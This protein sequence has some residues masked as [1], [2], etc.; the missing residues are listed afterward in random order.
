MENKKTNKNLQTS[1][2]FGEERGK[3]KQTNNGSAFQN[4][5]Q[6]AQ[7][8]VQ[9]LYRSYGDEEHVIDFLEVCTSTGNNEPLKEAYRFLLLQQNNQAAQSLAETTGKYLL[10]KTSSQ[11]T[12]IHQD[13]TGA[14]KNKRPQSHQRKSEDGI[15]KNNRSGVRIPKGMNKTVTPNIKKDNGKI[16]ARMNRVP[17]SDNDGFQTV[18]VNLYQTYMQRAQD[19]LQGL[20]ASNKI[21]EFKLD[22]F[23]RQIT[24]IIKLGF[25]PINIFNELNLETR[26]LNLTQD[27]AQYL[28]NQL[29]NPF[30]SGQPIKYYQQEENGYKKIQTE[31]QKLENSKN[32]TAA[33]KKRNDSLSDFVNFFQAKF[34]L[35]THKRISSGANDLGDSTFED[36]G[37]NSSSGANTDKSI[38]ALLDTPEELSPGMRKDAVKELLKDPLGENN[39]GPLLKH[40]VAGKMCTGW[41]RD[42]GKEGDQY[43]KDTSEILNILGVKIDKPINDG[44]ADEIQYAQMIIQAYD[45]GIRYINHEVGT[46]RSQL[47]KEK[48]PTQSKQIESKI[49]KLTNYKTE[50]FEKDFAPIKSIYAKHLLDLQKLYST[51]AM[52]LPFYPDA[53]QKAEESLTREIHACEQDKLKAEEYA[54]NWEKKKS[55]VHVNMARRPISKI[56][57]QEIKFYEE[58]ER[59]REMHEESIQKIDKK[60]KELLG[61]KSL[62]NDLK[63][64][65]EGVLKLNPEHITAA[66]VKELFQN[67]DLQSLTLEKVLEI[68][69]TM[70]QFQEVMGVERKSPP[71]PK[72]PKGLGKA[73]EAAPYAINT[74]ATRETNLFSIFTDMKVYGKTRPKFLK[75]LFQ[76]AEV[77]DKSIQFDVRNLGIGSTEETKVDGYFNISTDKLGEVNSNTNTPNKKN[78]QTKKSSSQRPASKKR[79]NK[80]RKSRFNKKSMPV[81]QQVGLIVGTIIGFIGLVV[82]FSGSDDDNQNNTRRRQVKHSTENPGNK[83][84]NNIDVKKPEKLSKEERE[85]KILLDFSKKLH[86]VIQK[87]VPNNRLEKEP[88]R[89]TSLRIPKGGKLFMFSFPYINNPKGASEVFANFSCS[90]IEE[91]ENWTQSNIE[92]LRLKGKLR[93]NN[94]VLFV[95]GDKSIFATHEMQTDRQGKKHKTL[96][97]ICIGN[98]MKGLKPTVMPINSRNIR[99]ILK[100]LRIRSEFIISSAEEY[101]ENQSQDH[102]D[103]MKVIHFNHTSA[104]RYIK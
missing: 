76:G 51:K 64:K 91:L 81:R 59:N 37:M 88:T 60:L 96:S 67:T 102:F 46:L 35:A 80:K 19:Q 77:V 72:Y 74:R 68:K 82:G 14:Q 30:V 58:D 26:V 66:M 13:P 55:T 7:T 57:R 99:S 85:K 31:I 69:Q 5:S 100:R 11:E 2:T 92:S 71:L 6:N 10:K 33:N 75:E 8:I 23:I 17:I 18:E 63:G 47:A 42:S 41:S 84:S 90:S 56:I 94:G 93:I 89:V 24:E 28:Y 87:L 45:L 54:N 98:K 21:E 83:T 65:I 86:G 32:D 70:T 16:A 73:L 103:R 15:P 97:L 44:L 52:Y 36:L 78:I 38:S 9:S 40:F 12:L 48:N 79:V 25:D 1:I 3:P 104:E 95:D 49:R 61:I 29:D 34:L 4:L 27:Q 43:T 62:S 20:T 53:L 101:A 50:C 22:D 39:T